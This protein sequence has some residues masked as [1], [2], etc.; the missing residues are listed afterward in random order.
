[1]GID[2]SDC[3][4]F[5][6]AEELRTGEIDAGFL[7]SMPVESADLCSTVVLSEPM[8]YVASS[9]SN[10]A[11]RTNLSIQ[12]LAGQ[13]LLVP[14]HDCAYR[15]KLQQEIAAAHIDTAAVIELN[16]VNA[17]VQC[18]RAGIGVALLPERTVSQDIAARRLTKLRWHA[19]LAAN[20]Y[21][22]RHRDKPLAGA[23]GAFVALVERYF[24]ELRDAAAPC[25]RS[26]TQSKRVL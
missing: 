4:Y 18:L 21:F 2:V 3:G 19:P 24:A 25:S 7:L 5:H 6:L 26:S 13:T 22:I 8:A 17:V 9:L 20:L 10:L 12:D 1:V 15:M 23:Y 14:K 11:K 16:S